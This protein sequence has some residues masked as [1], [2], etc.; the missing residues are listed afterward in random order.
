MDARPDLSLAGV[1][2]SIAALKDRTSSEMVAEMA[3]GARLLKSISNMPM[4]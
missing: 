2:G 1:T 3:P 4:A